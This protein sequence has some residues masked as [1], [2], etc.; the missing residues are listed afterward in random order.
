MVSSLLNKLPLTINF[1]FLFSRKASVFSQCCFVNKEVPDV[2]CIAPQDYF[3]GCDEMIKSKTLRYIVWLVVIVIFGGNLISFI[4]RIAYKDKNFVQNMLILNLNISDFLMGFYIV[5]MV[6]KDLEWGGVYY[7][8]DHEWRSSG[9]CKSFGVLAM[10]SS[11]VCVLT[12]AVITYDRRGKLVHGLAYDPMKRRTLMSII[13]LIWLIS[14]IIAVVP[15]VVK[16]YFFDEEKAEGFY[17]SNALCL[18]LQLPGEMDPAWEY[19]LAIFGVFNFLVASYMAWAYSTIFYTAYTSARDSGNQQWKKDESKLAFRFIAIVFTDILC[20]FPIAIL[21][22]ISLAG[23]VSDT[24]NHLYSWFSICVVPVNSAINPL[25]Y[26][27]TNTFFWPKFKGWF[28][29]IASVCRNCGQ[30]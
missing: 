18:P 23:F 19:C 15:A 24:E 28:K 29:K 5:A 25:I 17:G 14:I 9:A 8:R 2:T 22:F 20:W 7:L 13:A 6:Y 1:F 3:S 12:L 21:I 16:S 4:L 30:C 10:V 27:I 26:T 11:E